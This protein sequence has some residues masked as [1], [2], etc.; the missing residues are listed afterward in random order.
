MFPHAL[1]AILLASTL[2]AAS[3]AS[4]AVMAPSLET[5]WLPAGDETR[6]P[7]TEARGLR[8]ARLLIGLARHQRELIVAPRRL[9]PEQWVRWGPPLGAAALMMLE[10]DNRPSLDDALNV[11]VKEHRRASAAW[12]DPFSRLGDGDVAAVLWGSAWL[13]ARVSGKPSFRRTVALTGEAL[14]DSAILSHVLKVG[15][16]RARPGSDQFGSYPG[17]PAH[18]VS[19]GT[20]GS[21]PSGHAMAAVAV[22]TVIA[23]RHG[24]RPWV[25]PLAYTMAAG[26]AASRVAGGH[27]HASDIV[28]GGLVGH[29]VGRLVL[30]RHADRRLA[31]TSSWDWQVMP[32]WSPGADEVA[33]TV[34]LGR[35][36]APP[37]RLVLARMAEAAP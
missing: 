22:A 23:E 11:E 37:P 26:V 27:H 10:D 13:A 5:E 25:A 6:E 33:M 14:V 21:M 4:P 17:G 19:M 24:N 35:R 28:V 20:T 32:E 9:T 18:A 29:G 7:G 34:T 31:S 36:D 2:G 16:G 15:F 1:P 30:R 3:P 8:P 12:A